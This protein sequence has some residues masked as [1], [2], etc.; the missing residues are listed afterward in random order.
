MRVPTRQF[1][2]MLP[3]RKRKTAFMLLMLVC[4]GV[5]AGA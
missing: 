2:A 3:A 5:L 4:G 1:L